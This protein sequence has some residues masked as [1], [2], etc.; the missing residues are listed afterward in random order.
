MRELFYI[1]K[2]FFKNHIE[3]QNVCPTVFSS[4]SLLVFRFLS[5]TLYFSGISVLEQDN[6]FNSL[7][8]RGEQLSHDQ[9]FVFFRKQC[10]LEI[11]IILYCVEKEASSRCFSCVKEN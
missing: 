1:I 9:Y 8:E 2:H 11:N 3:S 7:K 6:V 10:A 4:I 5:S